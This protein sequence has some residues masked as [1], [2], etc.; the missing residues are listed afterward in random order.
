L[1]LVTNSSILILQSQ[2]NNRQHRVNLKFQKIHCWISHDWLKIHCLFQL[3]N[4][5]H[6]P[7]FFVL[8]QKIAHHSS[9]NIRDLLALWWEIKK[10]FNNFCYFAIQNGPFS[11]FLW[12][13]DTGRHTSNERTADEINPISTKDEWTDRKLSQ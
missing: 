11:A 10:Q 13:I 5:R 1:I 3:H 2:L 12:N 6:Q 9:K 7:T 8:H 4:S